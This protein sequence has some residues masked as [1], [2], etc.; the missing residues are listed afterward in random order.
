MFEN[1]RTYKPY[2]RMWIYGF[3]V[4]KKTID[5]NIQEIKKAGI[6]GIELQVLYPVA[7]KGN[8][9]FFSPEFFNYLNYIVDQC[10]LHDIDL[11]LTLGS[12]WPFGASF[13][14]K[15]MSPDILLPYQQDIIGPQNYSFD[16]TCILSGKIVHAILA[17]V[18][19]GLIVVDSLTDVTKFVEKTYISVWP[20]GQKITNLQVDEG[21]YRLYLFVSNEYRQRVGKAAPN[22]D[23]Y[24]MDHCRQD[25]TDLYID[26]LGNT[27][28]DNID[29]T[30]IRSVFCDSIELTGS[31]WTKYLTD[32]FKKR[33]GYELEK[34]MPVLWQ[35]IGEISPYIRADYYRTYGEL[36]VE[37]FFE[38][39]K[40]WAS[41]RNVK[42][43]LQAHGTWAD[44][45]DA[46]SASHI[47]EGETFGGGDHLEVNINHRRLAVSAKMAS[48]AQIVSNETY[49]WLRKPRF[50]VTLEMMKRA[51]DACFIDGINHIINHGYSFYKN[52]TFENLFYASSVISPHNTWWQYYSHLSKYIEN[53]TKFMQ[54]GRIVSNVAMLVPTT[55]IWSKNIMAEL[56]MSLKVENH[57]TKELANEIAKAGYWF[58]FVND[59]KI[60]ESSKFIELEK[61]QIKVL[62]IPSMECMN[63]E[64]VKSLEKIV[65][66]TKIVFMD[67]IPVHTDT[68]K[69]YLENDQELK[70]CIERLLKH[71]NA[72]FVKK[73]NL[74]L[75]LNEI[76]PPDIQI[77]N[78]DNI[79]Y[80][81]REND[82]LGKFIFMANV[83]DKATQTTITLA[84]EQYYKIYD[85]Q[86]D[87]Y[88][89]NF[90]QEKNKLSFDFEPNQ[91]IILLPDKVKTGELKV[92]KILKRKEIKNWQL[93]IQDEVIKQEKLHTWEVY[94]KHQYYSGEAFYT[95]HFSLEK[96]QEIELELESIHEVCEVIINSQTC[97]VLWKK[98]YTIDITKALVI[99]K[100]TIELKVVNLLY[101]SA[102]EFEAKMPQGKIS[103]HWPYLNIVVEQQRKDKVDT[104][105]EKDENLG[106]QPSGL[107]GAITLNYF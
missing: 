42:F 40:D 51:T 91:S 77:E 48:N 88:L 80:I 66:Q 19:N 97:G 27:L 44:I 75:H 63:L 18:E 11:D 35:D 96:I 61:N 22:M 16:F 3:N 99:G 31:N 36:T 43:R 90:H 68:F 78:N 13:I 6:G 92:K 20:W 100:N 46:Y 32:E 67:T 1:K 4:D 33:R 23:G 41:K 58:C 60:Q 52:E 50:L 87:I 64:T 84:S 2:T 105:R 59:R 17:K 49:T 76:Q 24:A 9:D 74:V 83:C 72:S 53:T 26:Q 101:N 14:T 81:I 57:I 28:L 55:E 102:L 30:K 15:E 86:Q 106:L 65:N 107:S 21:V 94:E 95:S 62:V 37:N 10:A 56:H 25:V 82:K 85:P 79:G 70:E 34:Y 89:T 5:L 71:E 7:M 69:N 103:E 93:K 73:T 45:I 12:G 29:S 8:I 39:I 47:P 38:R 98:P 104:F 54:N